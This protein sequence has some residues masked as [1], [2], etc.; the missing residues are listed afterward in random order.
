[1]SELAFREIEP[2][3]VDAVVEVP[4]SRPRPRLMKCAGY[5]LGFEI[6]SPHTLEIDAIDSI[7]P[8]YRYVRKWPEADLRGTILDVCKPGRSRLSAVR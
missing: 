1:M 6:H 4:C 3:A 8:G 7:M 5:L 2:N